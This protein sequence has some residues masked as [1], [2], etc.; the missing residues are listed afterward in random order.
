LDLRD[1]SLTDRCI[2]SLCKVLLNERC[3]LTKLCL[4][5]NKFSVN[6]KRPL[7]H[8]KDVRCGFTNG[9]FVFDEEPMDQGEFFI[10]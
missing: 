1:C 5:S 6:G 4:R 10:A 2:P 3:K 7:V 8:A 9:N